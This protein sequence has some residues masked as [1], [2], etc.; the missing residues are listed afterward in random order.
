MLFRSLDSAPERLKKTTWAEFLQTH[1]D[2][3]SAT[4]FFAVDIWTGRGL[5]RFVVLFV[6]ELSTRRVAITGIT[7]DPDSAWMS[8]WVAT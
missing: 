2:V 7:S 3:I 4:D 1:W 8:R 5:T 6:I